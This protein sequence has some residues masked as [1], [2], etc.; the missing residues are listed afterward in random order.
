MLALT[1]FNYFYIAG[2]IFALNQ[3]HT[4]NLLIDFLLWK[5]LYNCEGG[6]LVLIHLP[7]QIMYVCI[8]LLAL[9]HFYISCDIVLHG[10]LRELLNYSQCSV[11]ILIVAVI[12]GQF[13]IALLSLHQVHVACTH[14]FRLFLREVLNNSQSGLLMFL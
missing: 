4:I 6:L 9:N 12:S 8:L 7:A 1:F 5:V 2:S 11:L 10:L 14:L 3:V 13:H